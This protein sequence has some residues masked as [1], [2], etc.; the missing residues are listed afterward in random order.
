MLHAEPE[1][2]SGLDPSMSQSKPVGA[3]RLLSAT[4]NS[5]HGIIDTV[6][7]EAAFRQELMLAVLV[8]T[9]MFVLDIGSFERALL[10]ATLGLVL[11]VEL[12][13][14][15]IEAVVDRVGH[16]WNALSKKA[17]DAGSA[18]VTMSLAVHGAT[19]ACVL[20]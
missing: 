17:K 2:I 10:I 5:W 11:V 14:T 19:W 6:R 8:L 20:W 13:N 3:L 18:A 1:G 15:G 4:R 12:L 9:A 7:S 16:D